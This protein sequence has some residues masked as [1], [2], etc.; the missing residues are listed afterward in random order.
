MAR[1]DSNGATDCETQDEIEKRY[2]PGGKKWARN[3]AAVVG[4]SRMRS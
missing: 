3:A 2:Q 1:E 4:V